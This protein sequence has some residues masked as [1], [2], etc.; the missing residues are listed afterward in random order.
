MTEGLAR[1]R[2]APGALLTARGP[3]CLAGQMPAHVAGVLLAAGAGSRLGQ[4]KAL[5]EIGGQ[6]LSAA[7]S[8]LLRDGGAGRSSWSPARPP[9]T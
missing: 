4:P 3:R 1:S 8:A 6:S 2:A 9:S 7:G 5:V